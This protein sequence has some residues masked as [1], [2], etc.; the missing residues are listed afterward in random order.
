MLTKSSV[1]RWA[2]VLRLITICLLSCLN[3]QCPSNVKQPK[4]IYL[5]LAE[6]EPRDFV[7][8]H[9]AQTDG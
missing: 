5:A 8:A 2:L 1:V 9:P 7:M 3:T 4:N 6:S